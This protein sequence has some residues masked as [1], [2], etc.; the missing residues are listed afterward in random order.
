[1]YRHS[2]EDTALNTAVTD[3]AI[4]G[5]GAAGLTAA[6][7][8][9]LAGANVTVLE[10]SQVVGGTSAL[11]GGLIWAPG[12]HLE[13]ENSKDSADLAFDY[14]RSVFGEPPEPGLWSAHVRTIPHVV[15]QLEKYSRLRF[16]LASYPDS[17]AELP[18][19]RA[20]GRHLETKPF[21]FS[22][23][24]PWAAHMRRP[25]RRPV[26][27][28]DEFYGRRFK[29]DPIGAAWRNP[30][31]IGSRLLTNR[32]CM[33]L[34]LTSGLLAACIRHGVSVKLGWR[35]RELIL[36]G[37]RVTGAIGAT[38]AGDGRVDAA[39]GVVIATGGFEWNSAL[40][41]RFL[42]AA[43]DAPITPPANEGDGLRMAEEIGAQL[44][45]TDMA[46]WWPVGFGSGAALDGKTVGQ[47]VVAERSCP[48]SMVVNRAGKRFVNETSHNMALTLL[49]RAP[50]TNA[51]VN[52]PCWAIFD[53]RFR[54]RYAVLLS[55][56]PRDPN[57]PWLHQ[58]SSLKALADMT[59]IDATGLAE[60]V[61]RFN[62]FAASG[63]D[64]DF[65]RGESA[66]DR[67]AGDDRTP[68]PCLGPIEKPPFY[69][70]RIHLGAVG[71]KG[72]IRTNAHAQALGRDDE[73][74]RG[75]YAAGNAAATWLGREIVA[76]GVTLSL[77]LSMGWIA[78]RH[79]ATGA[80]ADAPPR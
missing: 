29:F 67:H 68:H 63:A 6:L 64:L 72:G 4:V 80:A 9:R 7:A 43:L 25:S 61:E 59:G 50:G 1:M 62:H 76:A 48:H 36:S 13:A 10:K 2:S 38:D 18:G 65:F 73:P 27:T 79:A 23:L 45:K 12:N 16:R 78:G 15:A 17:F 42:P 54:E 22:S 39:R 58:A 40:G 11:S 77:A 32:V 33:G 28:L 69:A 41:E 26:I 3:V 71:T 52:Q 51:L 55:V 31:L 47:L 20:F 49:E 19:G 46:W 66:Y 75:L 5:S 44:A 8:A 57:P 74:I 34:G 35:A 53:S 14:L 37:G 70:I 24:G 60:T 21:R 56:R 30:L